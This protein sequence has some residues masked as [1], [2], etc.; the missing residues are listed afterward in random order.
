MLNVSVIGAGSFGTALSLVLLKKGYKV[1]LYDRNKEIVDSINDERKNSKYLSNL[2]LPEGIFAT[3]DIEEATYGTE[4]I[5]L[6]VPSHVV[7]SISKILKKFILKNQLIINVGKGIEENSLKRLSEVINEELPENDVVILSGPSHAEEVSIG[8]PTALVAA[9][10]ELNLSRRV[11]DLFMTPS[12]RIYTGDDIVGVETAGA[13]K[14]V[15]ALCAGISDGMGFGDNAK[16]AIM[17][18]GMNE[19]IRIGTKLGGK[20]ETFMGLAGFGDLIVTCTSRHSRNRKCGFLIGSGYTLSQALDEIGM[21]VE[22]IKACSAFYRLKEMLQVDMPI[23]DSL[24]RVIFENYNVREIVHELMT[25]D[26][27][28]EHYH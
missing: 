4:Y 20:Y 15:I 11:Q 1:F 6:A 3:C 22:G 8:L 2:I 25:R 10:R 18:R 19:I 13:V 24:H 17:T 14:N 5:I 9:S 23:V 26:K 28:S 27:K 12:L 16:A 21:V 7:R